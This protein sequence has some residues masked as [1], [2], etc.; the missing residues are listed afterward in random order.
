MLIREALPADLPALIDL[1]IAAFRPLFEDHLPHMLDPQVYAHDHERW[2]DTYRTEVPLLHDPDTGR[3]VTLAEDSEADG[4]FLGYVGWQVKPDGSG[5]LEMVAVHPRARRQG[6]AAA[7]CRAALA[8][9]KERGVSVVHVGTGGDGF[10]A[11]ARA[12]YQSL[13]FTGYPVVDYTR[14]I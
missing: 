10:H 3:F 13:G 12:L 8:Q 1:T 9:L 6:V 11:P 14:A 5:R 4:G 7:V 2:E